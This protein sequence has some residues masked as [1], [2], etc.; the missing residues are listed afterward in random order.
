[1]CRYHGPNVARQN[2]G[3]V[4]GDGQD[5]LYALVL[6]DSVRRHDGNRLPFVPRLREDP[7]SE[8]GAQLLGFRIA[9]DHRDSFEFRN[10]EEGSQHVLGHD[11]RQSAT[12]GRTQDA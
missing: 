12:F 11:P 9:R 10:R 8:A 2:Q 6:Q 7:C 3:H 5:I 1:M 4:T